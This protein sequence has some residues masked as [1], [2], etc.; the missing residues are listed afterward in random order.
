MS[1][2]TILFDLDGTLVH[3]APDLVGAL[4][5]V[6][7]E[8]G[9]APVDLE[10]GLRLIGHGGRIMIVNGF[11]ARGIDLTAMPERLERLASRF[12]AVYETRIAAETRPFPNVEATL[13]RF[14]DADWRLGVCT[15]KSERLARLLLD[16]LDLSR[17]FHVITGADTFGIGKPDARPVLESIAVVGGD[18]SCAVLVGDSAADI[19][20][21]RAAGIP[22]IAVTF[23]YTDQPVATLAPDRLVDDF[24]D[25][26]PAAKM[27][28]GR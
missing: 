21:A 16:Q 14:A 10:S 17:L 24:A 4:N 5:L 22:V 15:N 2:P 20:A 9:E 26:W 11:A 8:E 1:R 23:G 13:A 6:L 19:H 25:I 12:V 27:L 18:P 3:S 28:I 7:A